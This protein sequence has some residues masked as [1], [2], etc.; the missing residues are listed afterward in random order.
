MRGR[1][2][3]GGAEGVFEGEG[4][5]VAEAGNEAL[6]VGRV[7]GCCGGGCGCGKGEVEVYV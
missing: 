2:E 3:E 1:R 4:V 5:E 7:G 6:V